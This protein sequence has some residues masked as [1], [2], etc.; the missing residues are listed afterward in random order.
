MMLFLI[1]VIT[2]VTLD[3]LLQFTLL[4]LLWIDFCIIMLYNN[5]NKKDKDESQV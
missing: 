3:N 5:I 1:L 4:Q 2:N